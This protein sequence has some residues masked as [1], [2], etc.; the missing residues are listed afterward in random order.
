MNFR[1][2]QTTSY[3]TINMLSNKE[4]KNK[5]ARYFQILEYI[6]MFLYM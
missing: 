5:D 3:K 4:N 1:V 2:E 6:I